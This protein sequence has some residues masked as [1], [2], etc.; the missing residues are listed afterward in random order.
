[1]IPELREGRGGG[2]GVLGEGVDAGGSERPGVDHL[3]YGSRLAARVR[4]WQ[5]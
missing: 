1:M 2:G 3:G 4:W 5:R